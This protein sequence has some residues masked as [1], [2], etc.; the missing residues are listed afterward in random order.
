M[1]DAQNYFDGLE[2]DYTI[3]IAQAPSNLEGPRRLLYM[4]KHALNGIAMMLYDNTNVT[5]TEIVSIS[6]EFTTL[7]G[8]D[9]E[10]I[11]SLGAD[12]F[13]HPNDW[14]IAE[15][16]GDNNLCG[17]Y[18]SRCKRSNETYIQCYVQAA[19]LSLDDF[20]WRVLT[21]EQIT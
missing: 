2:P 15:L 7:F 11:Q 19:S 12:N 6:P 13:F 17:Y 14:F 9:L 21:F 10:E 1:G 8:Y 20:T 5:S 4:L 16:H 18:S 3:E